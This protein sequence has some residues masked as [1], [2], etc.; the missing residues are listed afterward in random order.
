MLFFNKEARKKRKQKKDLKWKNEMISRALVWDKE[1]VLYKS[2]TVMGSR[3]LETELYE[4]MKNEE[5]FGYYFLK[6]DVMDTKADVVVFKIMYNYFTALLKYNTPYL[7]SYWGREEGIEVLMSIYPAL[8]RKGMEEK[9]LNV[10]F[11]EEFFSQL[12]IAYLTKALDNNYSSGVI[13]EYLE[14]KIA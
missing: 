10:E 7:M 12:D 11:F 4:L 1:S 8:H 14:S 9:R 6:Q 5:V 13:Q 3:K 2:I